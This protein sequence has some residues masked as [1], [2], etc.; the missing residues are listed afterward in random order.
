MEIPHQG[1][2]VIPQFVRTSPPGNSPL[3]VGAVSAT[4]DTGPPRSYSTPDVPGGGAAGLPGGRGGRAQPAAQ[5]VHLG[6][7]DVGAEGTTKVEERR[8]S[9][10]HAISLER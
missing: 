10:I 1:G 9:N 3:P 2:E 7:G 8:V 6:V 5:V 4:G